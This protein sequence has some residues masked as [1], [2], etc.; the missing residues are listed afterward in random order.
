MS[1]R[2]L[3]EGGK[4]DRL[5]LGGG[6]R[7]E[8]VI[9]TATSQLSD[10]RPNQHIGQRQRYRHE[11]PERLAA[12]PPPQEHRQPHHDS[13]QAAIEQ[14]RSR[15]GK[16]SALHRGHGARAIRRI[17]QDVKSDD[18][19]VAGS[20]RNVADHSGGCSSSEARPGWEASSSAATSGK[21]GI[22]PPLCLASAPSTS[23][24][25]KAWLNS[26]STAAPC[27]R[28]SVRATART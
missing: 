18:A 2:R 23:A 20:R 13:G 19:F 28:A 1:R 22:A 10:P 3:A 11:A 12:V 15:H 9:V 4:A 5:L 17:P 26:N 8:S 27:A 25:L 7:E 21:L 16:S 14:Q 24:A 6:R